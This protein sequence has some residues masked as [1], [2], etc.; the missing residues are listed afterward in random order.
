M[1]PP[2]KFIVKNKEEEKVFFL[3]YYKNTKKTWPK[4]WGWLDCLV[5]WCQVLGLVFLWE[6]LFVRTSWEVNKKHKQKTQ[7]LQVSAGKQKEKEEMYTSLWE[8]VDTEQKISVK[9]I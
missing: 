1:Y 5:L 4:S 6:L 3:I 8:W 2:A 9:S 7:H